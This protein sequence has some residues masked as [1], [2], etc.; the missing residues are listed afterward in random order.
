MFFR[1][2]ILSLKFPIWYYFSTLP[3]ESFLNKVL[4][5]Q[6]G[7]SATA[8]GTEILEKSTIFTEYDD[9]GSLWERL[10]LITL[11]TT[12][13]IRPVFWAGSMDLLSG[14]ATEW[15]SSWFA[16]LKIFGFVKYVPYPHPFP[17]QEHSLA[18][19]DDIGHA[20]DVLTVRLRDHLID[21]PACT[22]SAVCQ[23]RQCRRV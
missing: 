5:S 20:G 8:C 2:S 17:G 19:L 7:E 1:P 3:S 22:S 4:G 11:L 21:S 15:N 16:L 18:A 10:L 13:V 14:A 12:S 6:V 9:I 23:Y